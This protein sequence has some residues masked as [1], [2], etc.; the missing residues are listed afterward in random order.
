MEHSLN[1]MTQDLNIEVHDQADPDSRETQVGCNLGDVNR[2]N[3]G[4]FAS[5]ASFE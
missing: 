1:A 2:K 5:F 3:R 4:A